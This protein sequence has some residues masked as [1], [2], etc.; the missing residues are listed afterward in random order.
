MVDITTVG[1]GT[2]SVVDSSINV[3]SG[4]YES[5]PGI[6]SYV[7]GSFAP[8][9]IESTEDAAHIVGRLQVPLAKLTRPNGTAV[10]VKISA[11]TMVRYPLD[12]EIPAHPNLVRSVIMVGGFHQALQEDVDT[13]RHLMTQ[14]APAVL[15]TSLA[16]MGKLN[17]FTRE[18]FA[19]GTLRTSSGKI[20]NRK[21]I[22]T[23]KKKKTTKTKPRKT[24]KETIRHRG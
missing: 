11:I 7:R 16:L 15:A 12:T 6:K 9:A 5:Y 3:V 8:G 10:W 14:E 18:F 23:T 24:S 4:P 22:E 13:I 21:N 17:K 19:S 2:V 1:G 20:P